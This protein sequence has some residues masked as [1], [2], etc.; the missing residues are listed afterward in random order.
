[1][2]TYLRIR[3][4]GEFQ[5]Y[6][7][8]DPPWIKLHRKL[9]TSR[10]WVG[11]DDA[12]RVLAIALM[13]LA[14]GT[15]NKIPADPAYLKRVAYLN[16]DPDWM[17]LVRAGFIDLIDENGDL[18][19]DASKPLSK[20]TKRSPEER[21]EE[22]EKRQSRAEKT[23]VA[24]ERDVGPV[25]RVFEHWRSEFEHPRAH[26]DA[27]RRKAIV[28]ALSA[29]DEATVCAAIS[30][31]KH[32][33]YHMGQNER[34]AVYDDIALFLRDSTHIENGLN[35]ARS[36]AARQTWPIQFH[37]EVVAAYH[38][39]LPDL[40]PVRDWTEQRRRLLDERIAERVKAGKNAD[41]ITYWRAM[42]SQVQQSDFLRGRNDDWRCP[43]L[44][45]MLDPDNFL[46]VIEGAYATSKR[47]N[48]ADHAR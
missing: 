37:Q 21:R 7:D 6:K 31:Y 2:A 33:A 16:S 32:S 29:Y 20:R 19:A 43:G 41:Q 46:K 27:K 5:H 47:L 12:S 10:T 44:E 13:L 40:P 9:L 26:L 17:P 22:A 4:W 38:E 25:D 28:E 36:Q 11:S 15:D 30:G 1:M 45:W 34:R 39:L 48:G 8:R 3:E 42:F 35:F 24:Q 14:A 18:L 23:S